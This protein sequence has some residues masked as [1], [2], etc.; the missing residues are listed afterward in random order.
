MKA[1]RQQ[2]RAARQLFRLCRVDGLLNEDRVRQVAQ[3]LA[4]SG[5]R[6]SI[7]ILSSFQRLVRLD[8]DRHTAIIETATPLASDLREAIRADLAR[9]YGPNVDARFVE[10]PALI[11]GMR[12][13]VS[14]DVYDNSVR[15]RLTALEAML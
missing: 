13:R 8:R 4:T 1:K 14:S 2:Q 7:G 10:T 9:Q 3:R 5:R 12:I 6:D 11:G 15:A